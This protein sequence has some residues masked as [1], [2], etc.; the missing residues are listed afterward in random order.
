MSRART[1]CIPAGT[2]RRYCP[3]SLVSALRAVPTIT[4]LTPTS[5]VAA[6]AATTV[7]VTVPVC[8]A[9]SGVQTRSA[10]NTERTRCDPTGYLWG[11]GGA[12]LG[13]QA[14]VR[15]TASQ[16]RPL[17]GSPGRIRLAASGPGSAANITDTVIS[18]PLGVYA[19]PR[20]CGDP[21]YI[22]SFR[23][24]NYKSFRDS[25]EIALTPGFNVI[26]GQNNVGK[27]ALV[28]ALSLRAGHKPHRSLTTAPTSR[29]VVN[30]T[31]TTHVAIRLDQSEL[32]ELLRIVQ[33]SSALLVPAPD[34][35]S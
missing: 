4:T 17:E 19:S 12:S 22:A 23:I 30:S 5:G 11:G 31:S 13:R 25:P 3:L 24:V 7:P 15:N 2:L 26:V 16:E 21:M 8:C 20:L 34:G 6:S 33:A 18:S 27:S 35:M 28:E 1:A 10:A 9:T 14:W 29:S 32:R